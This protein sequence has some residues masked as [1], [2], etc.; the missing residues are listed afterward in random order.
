ML[1]FN[2]SDGPKHQNTKLLGRLSML[3]MFKSLMCSELVKEVFCFSL[4][5]FPTTY[6]FATSRTCCEFFAVLTMC[7]MISFLGCKPWISLYLFLYFSLYLFL[8]L[9]L[10][11]FNLLYR[12]W[13]TR[14][15][16][17]NVTN[18]FRFLHDFILWM[19]VMNFF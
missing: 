18:E 2:Y 1:Q 10:E 9:G 4:N 3:K 12:T 14:D 7:C 6:R 16:S 5:R 15:H 8:Y 17:F 11:A 13:V 19:E